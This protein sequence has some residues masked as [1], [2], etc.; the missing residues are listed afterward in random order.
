MVT[1]LVLCGGDFV[2]LLFLFC[3]CFVFCF[4]GG[5]PLIGPTADKSNSFNMILSFRLSQNTGYIWWWGTF[6]VPPPHFDRHFIQPNTLKM[7]FSALEGNITL[8]TK[9]NRIDLYMHLEFSMNKNPHSRILNK[10]S[11][12][13]CSDKPKYILY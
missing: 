4:F 11:I 10:Y 8:Y 5:V 6:H 13:C 1:L 9:L 12:I 7:T 2:L 3:F